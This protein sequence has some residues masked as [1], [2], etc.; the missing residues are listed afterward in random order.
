MPLITCPG[1]ST[2]VSDKAPACPK[3]GHPFAA[4]TVQFNAR[5]WKALQLLGG[6]VLAIGVLAMCAFLVAGYPI[7]EQPAGAARVT[8]VGLVIYLVGRLGR[9]WY[10]G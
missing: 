4:Q 8:A 6:L 7:G 5:K 9:W 10:H 2:Q 3:C 1:C